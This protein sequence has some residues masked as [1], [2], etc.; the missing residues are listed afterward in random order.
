MKQWFSDIEHHL[1][2]EIIKRLGDGTQ[3][4]HNSLTE[5]RKKSSEL[6]ETPKHLEFAGQMG[7]RK[8]QRAPKIWREIPLKV[9]AKQWSVHACEKTTE[10]EEKASEKE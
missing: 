6:G 8:L 2:T 1:R 10:S 9:L 4:E 7:R 3:L 5:L